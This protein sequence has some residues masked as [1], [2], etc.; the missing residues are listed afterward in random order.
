ML[1]NC[2]RSIVVDF[3]ASFQ[4]QASLDIS[5]HLELPDHLT[6]KNQPTMTKSIMTRHVDASGKLQRT[7]DPKPSF[8]TDQ[9]SRNSTE[10][11]F[12]QHSN[13]SINSTPKNFVTNQLFYADNEQRQLSSHGPKSEDNS[14][15]SGQSQD[16]EPHLS[17]FSPV[18]VNPAHFV[19][20]LSPIEHALSVRAPSSIIQPT[21]RRPTSSKMK[22]SSKPSSPYIP[23]PSFASGVLTKTFDYSNIVDKLSRLSSS[24]LSESG[25][26]S[27]KSS[28][29][30]STPIKDFTQFS[31]RDGPKVPLAYPEFPYFGTPG[32]EKQPKVAHSHIHSLDSSLDG[33]NMPINPHRYTLSQ[34]GAMLYNQRTSSASSRRR[35]STDADHSRTSSYNSWSSGGSHKRRSDKES[36]RSR[37]ISKTSIS[38]Q[39]FGTG[40]PRPGESPQS[41]QNIMK[42]RPYESD[43]PRNSDSARTKRSIVSNW[44][45]GSDSPRTGE[46][47]KGKRPLRKRNSNHSFGSDSSR[48]SSHTNPQER[49]TGRPTGSNTLPNRFSIQNSE[50]T[51]YNSPSSGGRQNAS[52]LRKVAMETYPFP[53][54][55]AASNHVPQHHR[56]HSL[57]GNSPR[58]RQP[59]DPLSRD[60]VTDDIPPTSPTDYQE[61]MINRLR[62]SETANMAAHHSHPV[63]ATSQRDRKFK[64]K[65]P[66]PFISRGAKQWHYQSDYN[67]IGH[68][69]MSSEDQ[70]Y[71]IFAN[72]EEKVEYAAFSD[73][74]SGVSGRSNSRRPQPIYMRENETID[75][76]EKVTP[77][78]TLI[79]WSSAQTTQL[80][81]EEV[82][83][84]TA[85]IQMH[86]T[87]TTTS[88]DS[89]AT[90]T[91]TSGYNGSLAL[92]KTP[93]S[94][95]QHMRTPIFTYLPGMGNETE[96]SGS[97]DH[98]QSPRSKTKSHIAFV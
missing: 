61:S 90:E 39:S 17:A 65:T 88:T 13:N 3:N 49:P 64:S 58:R 47:I 56:I 15:I 33:R 32:F 24:D 28:I 1:P 23:A 67:T 19:P 34:D 74:S 27:R 36:P 8:Q 77:D 95:I 14:S 68:S 12:A 25:T 62:T 43:S 98:H 83:K 35:S 5:Q 6:T 10:V 91:G 86:L 97:T 81:L 51:F 44:T 69:K 11:V 40:S 31:P 78:S 57:D 92:R 80:P 21:P 94:G 87:P 63:F 4:S 50:D 55:W 73:S 20:I 84:K 60:Y 22:V 66:D 9:T 52:T 79:A 71:D 54:D 70:R 89:E 26:S 93:D 2:R 76:L 18:S 29:Q 48:S 75:E 53:S 59:I 45:F 41:K 37:R 38:N 42:N 96:S 72:S 7:V 46:S 16:R 85:Q 30:R 82:I